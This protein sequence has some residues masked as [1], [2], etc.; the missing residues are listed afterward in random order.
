MDAFDP[1]ASFDASKMMRTDK[2]LGSGG[3]AKVYLAINKD[4]RQKYAVKIVDKIKTAPKLIELVRDETKLLMKLNHPHIIKTYSTYEDD[5]RIKITMELFTGDLLKFLKDNGKLIERDAYIIF[6][7]ICSAIDYLHNEQHIVHRDIKLANILFNNDDDM[8]VVLADFGFATH[9]EA[10][11]PLISDVRGTPKFMAPEVKNRTPHQGYPADIYALGIC[12]YI[13]VTIRNP[14][15][16]FEFH[17]CS[18]EFVDLLNKMLTPNPDERI[19]IR[20]VITHPWMLKF[21]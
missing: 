19:N 20:Q 4:T 8:T 12:L 2:L 1:D 3:S 6:R 21:D 7:Q 10:D 17:G 15:Y 14:A 11:D 5:N 9:R 13:M 18:A 16:K